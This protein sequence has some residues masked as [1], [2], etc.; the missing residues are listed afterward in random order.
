MEL[1]NQ[2]GHIQHWGL[3]PA[4]HLLAVYPFASHPPRPL[5]IL[6]SGTA[7]IRHILKTLCDLNENPPAQKPSIEIYFH[8]TNKELLCRALLFLHI[9]HETNL[10][11]SERIELFLDLYGNAMI[12]Y[13]TF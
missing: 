13:F 3:T 11:L 12:K 10:S 5:R 8:E 6:I 2:I 7:D 1:V 9:I 4:C